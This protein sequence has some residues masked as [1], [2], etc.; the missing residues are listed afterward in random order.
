MCVVAINMAL[1]LAPKMHGPRDIRG[2]LVEV[3]ST[4]PLLILAAGIALPRRA[5][6]SSLAE[7]DKT[8]SK[9]RRRP[10]LVHRRLTIAAVAR[11]WP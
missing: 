8:A 1:T 10:A 11:R 7:E 4:A 5:V 6:I 9:A 2:S 3:D